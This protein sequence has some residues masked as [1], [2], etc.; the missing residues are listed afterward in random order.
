MMFKRPSIAELVKRAAER[1]DVTVEDIKGPSRKKTPTRARY[2]V[3]Y[4]AR[5]NGCTTSQIGHHVGGR[6]HTTVIHGSVRHADG[7]DL[8]HNWRKKHV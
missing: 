8:P 2:W 7:E 1:F 6:D 3:F 4:H 5:V